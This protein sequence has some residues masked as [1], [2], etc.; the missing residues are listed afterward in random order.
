MESA[1]PILIYDGVCHLC[2]GLVRFLIERDPD[3]VFRFAPR[4]SAAGRAL[5]ARFGRSPETLDAVALVE[6][7][8]IRIESDATLRVL[9]LLGGAW[10]LLAVFRVV[11]APLRDMVYRYV[12][13]H[14]YGWFGRSESCLM[15]TADV[16]RRF[17]LEAG[18]E[19]A[20]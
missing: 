20:A 10:R 12:A 4:Q 8:R 18:D 3:A 16:R 14:R 1:R 7:H 13:R 9:F 15:P 6:G 19:A 17:L 11:P 5:L 2:D